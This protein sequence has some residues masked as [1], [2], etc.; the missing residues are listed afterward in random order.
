MASNIFILFQ[1]QKEKKVQLE[2]REKFSKSNQEETLSTRTGGAKTKNK[3]SST[4]NKNKKAVSATHTTI[5][6]M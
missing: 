1:D 5:V 2:Y 3:K 4:L 6:N